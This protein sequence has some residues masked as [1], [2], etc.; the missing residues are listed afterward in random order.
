MTAGVIM[1]R[2]TFPAMYSAGQPFKAT[3]CIVLTVLVMTC[4]CTVVL[5]AVAKWVAGMGMN[6]PNSHGT[7][8]SEGRQ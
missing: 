8:E 7:M 3:L 4:V 1:V 6:R 2:W 5:M